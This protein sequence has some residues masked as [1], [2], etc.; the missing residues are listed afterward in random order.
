MVTNRIGALQADL[1]QQLKQ[2]PD[3]QDAAI[4]VTVD[5]RGLAIV[6]ERV[7]TKKGQTFTFSTRTTT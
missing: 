5:A 6:D 1:R 4:Q 7:Q 3:V 2:E